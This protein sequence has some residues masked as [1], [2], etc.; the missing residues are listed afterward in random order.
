MTM[1]YL[2]HV[3]RAARVVLKVQAML[4]YKKASQ[5]QAVDHLR[6]VIIVLCFI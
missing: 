1:L 2:V 3:H 4:L 5:L 6:F